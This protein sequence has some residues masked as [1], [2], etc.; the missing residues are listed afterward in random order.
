MQI[1]DIGIQGIP[2]L[3]LFKD[4]T[5]VDRLVGALPKPETERHLASLL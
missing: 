4:G 3:L 1:G 5:Q 2:A